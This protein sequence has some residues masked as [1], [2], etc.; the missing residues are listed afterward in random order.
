MTSKQIAPT[1]IDEAG[2]LVIKGAIVYHCCPSTYLLVV[3]L[4]QLS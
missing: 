3:Q 2:M 4:L 1:A